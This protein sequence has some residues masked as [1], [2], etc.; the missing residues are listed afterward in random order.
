ML[1]SQLIDNYFQIGTCRKIFLQCWNLFT[2]CSSSWPEQIMPFNYQ[3]ERKSIH[4]LVFIHYLRTGERLT[5]SEWLARYER[6]FNPYHDE[7]G[8][9]TSPPGASVS[10]GAY[11]GPRGAQPVARRGGGAARA[12]SSASAVS[13]VSDGEVRPTGGRRNAENPSAQPPKASANG[14]RSD[15]VRNAVAP[16]TSHAETSFELRRRQAHLNSLRQEVGPNPDPITKADLDDFQKRLDADRARLDENVRRFVDPQ[17]NELLRAGLAPTDI[18]AGA[19]NIASGDGELRDYLSVAGAVP[20]GVAIRKLDWLGKLPTVTQTVD[21]AAREIVQLGG[22]HWKVRLLPKYHSHH[23]PSKWVSPL[24]EGEGPA[25][26][27][28]PKDHQATLSYGSGP[29]AVAHR[30]AQ[31]ELIEKGNFRAAQQLDIDDIK[32]KF[33]GRYDKSM[34]QML[35]DQQ[36]R[37]L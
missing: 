36:D 26:A 37:G 11:G 16:Q 9:F 27:M 31:A 25:I 22:P 30:K 17:T 23:I 19:I 21:G 3:T 13:G 1:R 15:L 7:W 6:K 32:Q 29:K 10:W 8:R 28:L 4:Q 35:K 20:V 12:A 18:L 34:D 14:F 24:R 33:P 5:N 2:L